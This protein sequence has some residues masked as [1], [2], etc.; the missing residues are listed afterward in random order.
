M[1]PSSEDIQNVLFQDFFFLLREYGIP[2]SPKEFL[3]FNRGIERGIVTSL[4]DL[5][6]FARL[7]FVRRVEHM[8]AFERAFVYYFYGVDIPAVAEGDLELLNTKAFQEWLREMIQS[9]K[10]PESVL[11]DMSADELMQ[12]F[13]A[14]VREQLEAHHGG[15]KW[16]GSKGNSPFGH[17]GTSERGVRVHG[18]SGKRSAI[19]V[20]GDRRYIA[21]AETNS[22]QDANVHQVLETMKHLENVGAPQ[23]L[24]LDETIRRTARNGGEIE[25][26]FGRELRDRISVV[27]FIDN[28]GS[29][30][31][32]YVDVTR[33]LFGKL[34][35]RF[36]DIST[37]YFHHTVYDRVWTDVRR[38]QP[39]LMEQILLRKPETRVVLV[40]D[41]AMAPE[42]LEW[43][44]GAISTWGSSDPRPSRYWLQRIAERFPRTVW[45][46][47]IRREDWDRTYGRWTIANVADVFH[48]EDMTLGGIRGMVEYMNRRSG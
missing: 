16:V 35:D 37:Y 27:L 38:T 41:A 36:H 18:Q 40:G 17:S 8:D 45:L 10:V 48:M 39:V 25:L 7:S 9:G 42:E 15:S 34:H 6:I 4:D 30:M 14:T 24:D 29:S 5:F 1:P 28:G 21:Y 33:R 20:V 19:K 22:L 44:H 12:Q 32:P 2:A 46:N 31:L 47:P 43:P 26:V 23:V 11:W 13:W 3:D